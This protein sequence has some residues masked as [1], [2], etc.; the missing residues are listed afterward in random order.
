MSKSINLQELLR[1]NIRGISPYSSAR[2]EFTGE[3]EVFL[4]ANENFQDFV[5]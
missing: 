2:S 3:A 5:E 1:P 4:D